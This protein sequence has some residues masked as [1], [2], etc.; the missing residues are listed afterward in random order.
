MKTE[1]DKKNKKNQEESL[2][3]IVS[4]VPFTPKRPIKRMEFFVG[5]LIIIVISLV[6][7]AAF[8]IFLGGMNFLVSLLYVTT[9]SY[10]A[11]T[12]VTKRLL[13]IKPTVNA[14]TFQIILFV[15]LISLNIL[16]S[17]QP[18]MWVVGIP[19]YLFNFYLL[20]KEGKA[21]FKGMDKD[22]KLVV[23]RIISSIKGSESI[24]KKTVEHM[25]DEA[26]EGL[27]Y[28]KESW[29]AHYPKERIRESINEYCST[30]GIKLKKK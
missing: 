27:G 10:I 1:V 24:N 30:H 7:G 22:E 13:D 4:R 29:Q 18:N 26:L 9:Y 12:W 19:L 6:I 17:I 3:A 11:T 5:S 2:W 16:V 14:K 20:L 21:S 8:S 15:I 25:I 23:D 28:S